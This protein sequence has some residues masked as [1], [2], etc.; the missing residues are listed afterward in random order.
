MKTCIETREI[1]VQPLEGIF[2]SKNWF[3]EK[4]SAPLLSLGMIYVEH[5][6]VF[7]KKNIHERFMLRTTTKVNCETLRDA[8]K[9]GGKKEAEVAEVAFQGRNDSKHRSLAL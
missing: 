9:T 1:K 2:Y 3:E 6:T 5:N 8:G 4:Y 7:S